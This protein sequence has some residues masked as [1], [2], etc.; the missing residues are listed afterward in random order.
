MNLLFSPSA[1]RNKGPIFEVI[2]DYLSKDDFVFEIASGTGQHADFIC[3]SIKGIS[4]QISEICPSSFENLVKLS[5]IKKYTN[6]SKLLDPMIFDVL[7]YDS[8]SFSQKI[9]VIVN[10]NMLHISSEQ[11]LDAVFRF[12]S[13]SLKNDGKLFF[14][15]PFLEKDV[16]TSP[17]NLSFDQSLKQ[18]NPLWGIRSLEK[19]ID[20]GKMYGFSLSRKEYMPSHNLSLI[21]EFAK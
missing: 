6:G 18:R 1:E 8:S 4:W 12:A 3:E 5:A 11:T 17:S 14:Y 16:E 21:F 2:K 20:T 15:G 19:V 13:L 10:I 7:K 9:D